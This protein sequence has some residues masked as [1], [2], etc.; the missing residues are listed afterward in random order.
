MADDG[1][2]LGLATDVTIAWLA[3]SNTRAG[4]DDVVAMLD[5]VHAALRR[6]KSD[7]GQTP[8]DAKQGAAPEYRPAVSVRRSLASPEHIISMIDGKPYRS[9]TRHLRTHGLT[10]DQYRERYGLKPDYPMVAPDYSAVRSAA[11]KQHNFGR[12]TAA[13]PSTEQTTSPASDLPISAAPAV[14]ASEEP[15]TSTSKRRRLGIAGAKK[16]AQAHLRSE[17]ESTAAETPSAEK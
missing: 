5:T 6:L 17:A 11:A 14:P 3:N 8:A 9:L 13:E 4:A 7:A 15:G 12:P 1:E 2:Q 16:A 10:A